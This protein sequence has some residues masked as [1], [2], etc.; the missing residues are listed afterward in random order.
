M[1][2]LYKCH[3][4][5]VYN[6]DKTSDESIIMSNDTIFQL[7]CLVDKVSNK[8]FWIANTH[9]ISRPEYNDTI[10]PREV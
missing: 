7:V 5:N 4:K 1:Y 3:K 9:L 8:K 2:K 10:K 6:S